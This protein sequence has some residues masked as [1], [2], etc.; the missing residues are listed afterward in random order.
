MLQSTEPERL[1]NKEDLRGDARISLGKGHRIDF[2]GGLG[3]GKVG[4]RGI[5]VGGKYLEK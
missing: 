3:V 1:S 5:S 4:N 2:M